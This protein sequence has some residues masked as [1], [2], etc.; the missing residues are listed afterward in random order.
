MCIRDSLTWN[1]VFYLNI[2]HPSD[3]SHLC[4]DQLDRLVALL[5]LLL[6]T[7]T[8]TTTT[9][10]WP[11]VQDYPD[12]PV[13]EETFL[14]ALKGSKQITACHCTYCNKELLYYKV[15]CAH[16]NMPEGKINKQI[17]THTYM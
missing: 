17:N 5:L 6:L 13:P 3:Y 11:F 2:T 10:L 12:E 15:H 14:V 7:A 16:D 9:I 1:S 4:S 8:T